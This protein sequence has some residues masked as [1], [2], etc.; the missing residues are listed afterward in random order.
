QRALH[1]VSR[2]ILSELAP[3]VNADHG[4]FYILAP[5]NGSEPHMTFQAGYAYKPRRG[6]ATEFRLGEGLVGQCALDRRRILLTDVP[7]NYVRISS[8]LGEATPFNIL[9]LPV[10]F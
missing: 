1:T 3:L 2:M 5:G 4:A 6:L 8:G 7:S 10:L 9:I